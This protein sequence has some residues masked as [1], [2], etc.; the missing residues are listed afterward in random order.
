MRRRWLLLIVGLPLYTF[1]L[2]VITSVV[3][4]AISIEDRTSL[5]GADYAYEVL[6]PIGRSED[7]WASLGI[8]AVIMVVT[9]AV[10]LIPMF[11]K[12]PPRGERSRPLLVS[13]VIGA[14][15]AAVLT[16]GF[17]LAVIEFTST[18]MEAWEEAGFELGGVFGMT[19]L[20]GTLVGS[21][22][23]WSAILLMFS[24]DIWADRALGRLVGLLLGGT[25]LEV[26]VVVPLDIM[27][28][29]RTDCYCVAGTFFALCLSVIATLWLAG[30]GIVIALTSKKH[31]LWRETH[32][33][34]CGYAKGP[35]PGPKCPECGHAWG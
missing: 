13:L 20:V 24:R 35:S 6:R 3:I 12:R 25:L 9:Q 15:V 26:L 23:L 33:E 14:A 22:A 7:W 28:R 27:V 1:A 8:A 34:R 5:K 21:W 29:R 2:M 31:R 18:V 17:M 10:F 16:F 4:G 11:G 32:C 30:P 19:V